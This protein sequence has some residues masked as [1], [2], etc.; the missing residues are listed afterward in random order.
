MTLT[1]VPGGTPCTFWMSLLSDPLIS[2]LGVSANK[3][4]SLCLIRKRQKMC[5]VGLLPGTG[6]RN[7][8]LSY[9]FSWSDLSFSQNDLARICTVCWAGNSSLQ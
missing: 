8:G 9:R 1:N 6:L 3:L 4:L 2:G 5:T 7:T